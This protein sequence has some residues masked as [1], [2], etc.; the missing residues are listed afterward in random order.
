MLGT[1]Q[2]AGGLGEEDRG[3][4]LMKV[5]PHAEGEGGGNKSVS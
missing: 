5:W 1:V 3:L 4:A 2:V